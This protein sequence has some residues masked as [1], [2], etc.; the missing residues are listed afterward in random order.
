MT[1][2]NKARDAR[3]P[4]SF[5]TSCMCYTVKYIFTYVCIYVCTTS[6]YLIMVLA[7]MHVSYA[8]INLSINTWT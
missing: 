1:Y 4:S 7:D 6:V 8:R 3:M 5:V 2:E